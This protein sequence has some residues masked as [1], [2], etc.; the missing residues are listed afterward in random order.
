MQKGKEQPQVEQLQTEEKQA[1]DTK[2]KKEEMNKKRLEL[3]MP[4]ERK[5]VGK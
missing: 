2:N 3:M 5:N 4:H 1:S